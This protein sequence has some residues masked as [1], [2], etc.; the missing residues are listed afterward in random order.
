MNHDKPVGVAFGIVSVDV[1]LI[2]ILSM[3]IPSTRAAIYE[4]TGN[5]KLRND[6]TRKY[7]PFFKRRANP[8]DYVDSPAVFPSVKNSLLA[9]RQSLFGGTFEFS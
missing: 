8:T 1:S 5:S 6:L 7:F 4:N 9:V 3:L 2:L